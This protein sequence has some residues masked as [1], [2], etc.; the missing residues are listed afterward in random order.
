MTDLGEVVRKGLAELGELPS[1]T[2]SLRETER[3]CID[4]YATKKT[5]ENVPL[6]TG[7]IA[8]AVLTVAH[9]LERYKDV[10]FRNLE[11][12]TVF[13]YKVAGHPAQVTI[14]H[15]IPL[16]PTTKIGHVIARDNRLD[17]VSDHAHYNHVL[18]GLA[19]VLMK[20]G[21]YS[22]ISFDERED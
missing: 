2:L 18:K 19:L 7:E 1:D 13:D 3:G 9:E 17:I 15:S 20:D 21:S 12:T 6:G 16:D 10:S 4:I 8:K 5:P 22:P 14:R 11:D